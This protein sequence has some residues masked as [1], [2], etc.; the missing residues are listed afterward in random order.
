[1]K[2]IVETCGS[3][4]E[5]GQVWCE[6]H[7]GGRVNWPAGGKPPSDP[8]GTGDRRAEATFSRMQLE[9]LFFRGDKL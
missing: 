4:A 6:R 9:K 2:C 7:R 3:Q 8:E 1:M 5:A